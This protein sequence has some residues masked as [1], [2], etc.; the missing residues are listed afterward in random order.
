MEEKRRNCRLAGPSEVG[1]EWK[2]Q[3]Y[4]SRLGK[5]MGMRVQHMA[6]K[7]CYQGR[8]ERKFL[9][10]NKVLVS[11]IIDESSIIFISPSWVVGIGEQQKQV[12]VK[13]SK[14]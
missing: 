8:L 5:F 4:D 11:V 3:N 14:N 6:E 1:E 7:I 12:N 10:N 13:C 9:G 2:V